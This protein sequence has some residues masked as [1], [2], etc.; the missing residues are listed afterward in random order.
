M[1]P[2]GRTG[3]RIPSRDPRP[4]RPRGMQASAPDA[5]IEAERFRRPRMQAPKPN[6]PVGPEWRAPSPVAH[7]QTT[8]IVSSG[9]KTKAPGLTSHPT[10]VS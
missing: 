1:H 10:A 2:L 8:R 6:A 5:G 9:R 4:R 3:T 7:P